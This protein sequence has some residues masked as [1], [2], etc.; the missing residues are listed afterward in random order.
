MDGTRFALTPVNRICCS[1][2]AGYFPGALTPDS[3]SAPSDCRKA[4]QRSTYPFD[5][6]GRVK[7]PGLLSSGGLGPPQVHLGVKLSRCCCPVA[8]PVKSSI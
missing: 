6:K 4:T 3:V 2:S 5:E 1:R 7:G 8:R